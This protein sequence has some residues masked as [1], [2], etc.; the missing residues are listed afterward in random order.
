MTQS[1][2]LVDFLANI[3]LFADVSRELLERVATATRTMHLGPGEVLFREGD[4]GTDIY[5]VRAGTLDILV[6]RGGAQ[7]RRINVVGAGEC[8]GEMGLFAAGNRLATVR[9]QSAVELIK[10]ERTTFQQ[11]LEDVPDLKS[12]LGRIIEQRLPK[13]RAV[14][15]TLFGDVDDAVLREIEGSL[16][17]RRLTRGGVLFREGD[18]GDE[19]F[20]IVHGRLQVM[21]QSNDGNARVVGELG[22]GEW[23]GEMTLLDEEPRSATVVAMRD[24]DLLGLSRSGFNTVVAKHPSVLLPMIKVLS[25]RLRQSNVQARQVSVPPT[26]LAIAVVPLTPLPRFFVEAITDEFARDGSVMVLS[27]AVFDDIHG[28]KASQTTADDPRSGHLS[29]WLSSNEDE[30]DYILYIGEGIESE[31]TRRCLR[32]ADRVIYSIDYDP[33]QIRISAERLRQQELAD[34]PKAAIFWHPS[35]TAALPARTTEAQEA[36]GVRQHFHVQTGDIADVKRLGRYFMNRPIGLCMSGGGARGFA[37]IGVYRAL[38][39]AGIAVDRVGGTS[40]GAFIG[41]LIAARFPYEQIVER[42]RHV[43]AEK[44]A[45]GYTIPLLSLLQVENAERRLQQTFAGA[46]FEDLWLHS[47]A[48]STNLTTSQL[49]VFRSGPVWRA[50]RASTAVPGLCPPVFIKGEVFVDG[51]V[52][53]NMPVDVM[54]GDRVGPIIACDV[55]KSSDFKVSPM[56]ESTPSAIG[57][58]ARRWS[59]RKRDERSI[60]SV[61]DI[62]M[63]TM[64]C[65]SRLRQQVNSKIAYSYLTPPVGDYRL[66]DMRHFD[67]LVQAGYEYAADYIEKHGVDAV[68]HYRSEFSGDESG[69]FSRLSSEF[70]N[71]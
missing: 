22:P 18:S 21:V 3:N 15:H 10:L 66:L 57:L 54:A 65:T 61:G 46:D 38:T 69:G 52:L 6:D 5:F 8:V 68:Y 55:T 12:V 51:A 44:S 16:S 50:I 63:R 37:H 35:G 27:A 62:L 41:T 39:E 70:D 67:E 25:K 32:H 36:L 64:D 2:D 4:P 49:A 34:V 71:F 28:E 30:H 9:A 20:M 58:M 45:F 23:V 53:D 56:L 60:P 59:D 48:C 26:S 14:L 42:A 24:T 29:A 47:F 43:L 17:W 19:L 11:L 13:L 7:S 1:A 40:I 31:W 33:S